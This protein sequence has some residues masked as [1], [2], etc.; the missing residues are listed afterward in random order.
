MRSA[1]W[2]LSIILASIVLWMV[3]GASAQRT[4]DW[5]SA[6]SL[7]DANALTPLLH[8]A[9]LQNVV[10][11]DGQMTSAAE[12]AEASP[13]DVAL[14][15]WSAGPESVNSRWWVKN[16][17]H[18]LYLLCRIEWPAEDVDG[19]DG[20]QIDYFWP[21]GSCCPWD[22]SDLGYAGYDGDT[23]DLYGWDEASWYRDTDA[24]GTNDVEGAG[25]HDGTHYWF[26]FRKRLDSGDEFDWSFR[27]GQTVGTGYGGNL[28]VSLWDNSDPSWWETSVAIVLA[29]ATDGTMVYLPVVQR[30]FAGSQPTSTPSPTATTAPPTPTATPTLPAGPAP[31]AIYHNGALLTMEG[32]DWG[33]EAIAIQ[34]ELIQAVGSDGEVL[35]LRGPSTKVIDL[36]GLCLMPGFVD[37]HNH[38]F[39][40]AY[41]MEMDWEASQQLA[42]E[43][44]ITTMA[45]MYC[46]ETFVQDIRQFHRDGLLRLR[47]SLYMLYTDVCGELQGDWWKA[48][49]PT[50]NFGEMLRIGG[51]KAFGDG[52]A[53]G[54]P[55]YSFDDP[56]CSYGDLWL[57]QAQMNAAV[58]E[59]Q[60]EGYQIA[61]HSLGDRSLEQIM[62]AYE[63]VL[64]GRPNTLR[65]RI[66][67]NSVVRDDQLT[68]YS[69][70]GVVG[71]FFGA[72]PCETSL[73]P[74]PENR[75]WKWRWSDMLA[76]NPEVRF[77]WHSDTPWVGP[78][79]NPLDHLYS[80]VTA[81]EMDRDGETICDT[82]EWL[83]QKTI[84]VE[85]ALPMMTTEAAY[86]L[87]RETEIGS[88][89]AGKLADI[90]VLSDNPTAVDPE[91]IKDIEVLVTMIGGTVEHCAP[92]HET[93]CPD[94]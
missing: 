84:T 10:T 78:W 59:A 66:E 85:Q 11:L 12:W 41:R 49:P 51:L 4:R 82:P 43:N 18:W 22:H 42:L 8:S 74:P 68:R 23:L 13:L 30:A 17:A 1:K 14:L 47:T 9:Y 32:E 89:E 93:L 39:N 63:L 34:G 56:R 33:A 40:D 87:F 91:E 3:G 60:A 76:A 71:T 16:D 90:I 6:D 62:D 69:E 2:L 94:E 65:H 55:A 21:E 7:A 52:G 73:I 19:D 53:C 29:E 92:G 36:Q 38:V 50:R 37:P 58:A 20:G 72:F 81:Y 25:S 24:G 67:H 27:P 35:A 83:S 26:E 70:L 75:P 54:C 15:K 48:Y 5:P 79:A 77:A 57:T 28:L 64:D 86:A 46:D 61:I 45:N 88:L 44:G 80:L 31:D